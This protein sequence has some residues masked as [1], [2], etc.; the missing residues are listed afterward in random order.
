MKK[1][2]I[3]LLFLLA[4]AWHPF[5]LAGDGR[6]YIVVRASSYGHPFFGAGW[7]ALK[8]ELYRP[9]DRNQYKN[10]A[11]EKLF[12]EVEEILKKRK[13]GDHWSW[14]L[15]DFPYILINMEING[16]KVSLE[17]SYP[18]VR[19]ATPTEKAALEGC[20]P[21]QTGTEENCEGKQAF[22]EIYDAI[23]RYVN[24]QLLI[25]RK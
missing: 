14:V 20:R 8:I 22:D 23:R 19:P 13:T 2:A 12:A 16:R 11:T 21:A 24:A 25:Q 17:S 9:A 6:D 3:H 7:D 15:P 10:D 18:Y 5:A 1:I 4:C